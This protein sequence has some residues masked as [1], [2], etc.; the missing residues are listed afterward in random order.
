[1]TVQSAPEND[2]PHDR[3]QRPLLGVGAIVLSANL[4]RVLLVQRGRQPAKGKWSVPGGLVEHGEGLRQACVREVFEET[5]LRVE[6]QPQPVKL[7]ERVIRDDDNV[8][9]HY[10]VVDFWGIAAADRLPTAQSDVM[11][12]RW[13]PLPEIA[14]LETTEGLNEVIQ[15]T[16]RLAKGQ[17]PL[18]PLLQ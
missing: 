13:T 12:A 9:Y 10:I 8:T 17:R 16:L 15:R 18:T 11:A 14:G 7:L 6:L 1:M 3:M 4:D 2:T 5:G